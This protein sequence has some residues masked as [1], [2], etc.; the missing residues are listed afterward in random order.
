M[1]GGVHKDTVHEVAPSC[2]HS[3]K[4]IKNE[5]D[6]PLIMVIIVNRITWI[7]KNPLVE[8][9]NQNTRNNYINI[10]VVN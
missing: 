5:N 1:R 6:N 10:H 7:Q 3:L 9:K 8:K 4:K 2:I